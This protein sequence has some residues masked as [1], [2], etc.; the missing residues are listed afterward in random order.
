MGSERYA[1]V[2]DS[3]ELREQR[4]HL[5][6]SL[7]EAARLAGRPQAYTFLARLERGERHT[8][9]PEFAWGL[10]LALGIEHRHIKRFFRFHGFGAQALTH[11]AA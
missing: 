1:E 10:I 8:L 3:V 4:E 11:Q 9:S 7:R 2:V 6:L 5:G